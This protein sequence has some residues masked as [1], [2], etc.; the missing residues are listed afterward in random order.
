M[1]PPRTAWED[2]AKRRPEELKIGT[3]AALASRKISIVS[4]SA[5][6]MGLSMKTGLRGFKTG[7]TCSRCGR[8]SMLSS[9]TASTSRHISSM[10]PQ[11]FTSYFSRRVLAYSS[12]REAL[13][14]MSGLPPLKA[15]TTLAP[16]TW[17]LAAG[18]LSASVK[19]TTCEVSQPMMPRRRSAQNADE[20]PS[21]TRMG[22]SSWKIADG[23]QLEGCVFERI[24][25]TLGEGLT[26]FKCDSA[27]NSHNGVVRSPISLE[28]T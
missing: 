15:A 10:L 9:S 16:E 11:I 3:L 23:S 2:L 1:E 13:E 27:H 26:N 18:L 25:R 4:R 22:D 14:G 20:Q 24:R 21:S 8:P 19:A 17:A 6:A 12:T 28:G 7:L 5:P